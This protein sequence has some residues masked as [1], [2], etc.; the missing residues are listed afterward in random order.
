LGD[1]HRLAKLHHR[2]YFIFGNPSTGTCTCSENTS[3]CDELGPNCWDVYSRRAW[4][5]R[6]WLHVSSI[7][8]SAVEVCSLRT[9]GVMWSSTD[10]PVLPCSHELSR[11][12]T[13]KRSSARE[14]EFTLCE[15]TCDACCLKKRK[16]RFY[17]KRIAPLYEDDE[18]KRQ[19]RANEV[20]KCSTCKCWKNI[21]NFESIGRK[22][23]MQCLQSRQLARTR[24]KCSERNSTTVAES[25]QVICT[26]SFGVNSWHV[27]L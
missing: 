6:G 12:S 8:C 14:L 15:K 7:E 21:G 10:S 17:T 13:C 4:L 19:T 18:T 26:Q 27:L 9:K 16:H 3:A 2:R 22:T 11:C 20:R 1:G 24:A 23:C 5:N 25:A